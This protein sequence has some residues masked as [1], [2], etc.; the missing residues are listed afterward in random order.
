MKPSLLLLVG[1]TFVLLA[2]S[3]GCNWSGSGGG[4]PDPTFQMGGAIQIPLTLTSEV[5]T[6]AGT[7]DIGHADGFGT[8]PAA[9]FDVPSGFASDGTYYYVV[10]MYDY[11]IRRIEIDTGLVTTLA[12]SGVAGSADGIG[13]AASFSTPTDAAFADD[14]L[15]ITDSMNNTIRRIDINTAEVITF[16]GSGTAGSADGIGTAAEFDVPFGIV[17]DG[18]YLYVVDSSNHT[19]RR[20]EIS[21]AEVTTFAGTGSSGSADGTGTAAS[22][23]GPIS[24]TSDN[25]YLY[26]VD[27]TGCLIRQIEIIS[28][29]VTTIAGTGSSGNADGTGTAASFSSP[30]GIT[31]D[32]VYLYVADLLNHTIRQIEIGSWE[33]T[34]IAGDGTNGSADGIGTAATFDMPLGILYDGADL[35]VSGFN[36]NTLRKIDIVTTEVTTYAGIVG[37]RG[38]LD[39]QVRGVMFDLPVRITTD[40]T[41]LYISDSID[42]QLRMIDIATQE[43]TTLN[44]SGVS[45]GQ[46]F[47]LTTDGTNIYFSDSDNDRI[48]RLDSATLEVTVIAGSGSPGNADGPGA[49]ASFDGPMGITTDGS[50]LYVADANNRLIRR[51]VIATAEVTTLA[52]SGVNGS[53]DGIGTAASFNH[54][55][56]LTT[57]GTYL[58]VADLFGHTIRKIEIATAEVT[59]LAGTGSP[60][61]SN[62]TGTAA[63]FDGPEGVTCDSVNLYVCETGN[64]S[65][66]VIDLAT[67]E[68]TTLAGTGS[69][70]YVDG[71]GTSA[72]FDTPNSITTDGEHLYICDLNNFVIRQIK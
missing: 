46:A 67:A 12:G 56:E 13:T 41:Y 22:F 61:F 2:C 37:N 32:G 63:S 34:T 19:I 51:I 5:T 65:V 58:Y 4:D 14:Y 30:A 1:T 47:G 8:L 29:V 31:T 3:T 40:G 66:R 69:T 20:I 27:S 36:N 68:V 33:V 26:V 38:Y 28:A 60:G 18:L 53:A 7:G 71:L 70:G 21:T 24:L 42:D 44:S 39:G 72:S 64:H 57:D 35:L 9:L 15:Y 6:F 62:G 49:A 50:S 16:A 55:V 17:H 52:G 45:F 25:G 59:T 11:R 54:P 10:D 48:C 43:V 23:N